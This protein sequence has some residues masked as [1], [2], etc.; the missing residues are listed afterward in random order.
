MLTPGKDEGSS[1]EALK[2]ERESQSLGTENVS[3]EVKGDK[4]IIR[5][6]V[7]SQEILDKAIIAIGNTHGI[8]K[9]EADVVVPD[10][11]HAVIFEA[12]KP[13]LSHPDKIYPGQVLRISDLG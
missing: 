9:V 5:G 12:N 4:A 13:M 6:D 1:A 11:E 2:K 10:A 3:V 8:S 7:S